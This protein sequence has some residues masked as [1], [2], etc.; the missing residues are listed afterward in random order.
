MENQ[1][2]DMIVVGMRKDVAVLVHLQPDIAFC[3]KPI[4]ICFR[5]DF[6]RPLVFGV[7][8]LFQIVLQRFPYKLESDLESLY[9]CVYFNLGVLSGNRR[10]AQRNECALKMLK[11]LSPLYVRRHKLPEGRINAGPKP[12]IC[13]TVP[14]RYQNMDLSLNWEELKASLPDKYKFPRF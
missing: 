1:A 12:R 13:G 7:S 3:N 11:T 2:A 8:L 9:R 6:L 4:L 5:N 10:F 14:P